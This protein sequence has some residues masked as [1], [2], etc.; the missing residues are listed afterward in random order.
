MV[1][2]KSKVADLIVQHVPKQ[3]IMALSDAIYAASKRS[4]DSAKMKS[5]GHRATALGLERYLNLNETIHEVFEANGCN[6][7]KLCGNRIVE[8]HSG[9]FTIARESYND[10]QWKK[11][12]R[13]KR[14]QTLI[15]ENVFVEKVVQPDLFSDGSDVPKATLFVVCRFSGSLQTQPEAPMSIELVVP[16]SDGKSWVFHEPLELF[17]TRYDVVPS[18][19]DN[20]FP[21]LKKGIIKK[22]GTEEDDV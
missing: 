10:N 13:S 17:L 4:F 1:V 19:E 5:Q 16:S 8:G 15:A 12:F 18:Q 6:P 9:I 11:L 3:L 2:K 21:G 14:K 7:G 22:D 20:A